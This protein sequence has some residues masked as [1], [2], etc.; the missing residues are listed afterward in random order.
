[1]LV[2]DEKR[3]STLEDAKIASMMGAREDIIHTGDYKE[4]YDLRAHGALDGLKQEI[5]ENGNNT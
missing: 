2:G 5:N 3:K 4:G 1:M